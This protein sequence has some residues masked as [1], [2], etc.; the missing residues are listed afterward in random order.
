[1]PRMKKFDVGDSVE[2]AGHVWF[3]KEIVDRKHVRPLKDR[4]A[5][6][7]VRKYGRLK[8]HVT[9]TLQPESRFASQR[10]RLV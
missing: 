9:F 2:H 3:V 10:T 5:L 4:R 7:L 1:M 6:L 8:R